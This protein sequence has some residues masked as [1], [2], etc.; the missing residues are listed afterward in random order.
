MSNV[1]RPSI[2]PTNPAPALSPQ[3]AYSK[4]R[5]KD[6]FRLISPLIHQA[7]MS[8]SLKIVLAIVFAIGSF[9]FGRLFLKSYNEFGSRAEARAEVD[10]LDNKSPGDESSNGN[11][12]DTTTNAGAAKDPGETASTSALSASTPGS[13]SST[14]AATAPP[15]STDPTNPTGTGQS[16]NTPTASVTNSSKGTASQPNASPSPSS[17]TPVAQGKKGSKLGLYIGCFLVCLVGFGGL[18]GHGI[19]VYLGQRTLKTIYNDEGDGM[20][21]PEYEQAEQEWANGNHLDAIRLMREYLLKNPREQHVALRIAEIYEKDLKNP[22]ASALEYEEIL[23]KKLSPERWGWAAIHLCNLYYKLN[24]PDKALALL[25]RLDS[26]YGQTAAA[27]KARKRLALIESGGA[28]EPT[29]DEPN[30]QA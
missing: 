5:K 22:L 24:K 23:T 28:A 4:N 27:E 9:V 21:D 26:E 12:S 16:T 1:W 6:C 8:T 18:V 19:S 17:P 15:S 13:S 11:G 29:S 3:P 25:R 14:N 10:L 7:L 30:N 2:A 20:S